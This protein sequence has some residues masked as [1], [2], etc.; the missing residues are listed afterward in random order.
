MILHGNFNFQLL[1]KVINGYNIRLPNTTSYPIFSSSRDFCLHLW[2]NLFFRCLLF[3]QDTLALFPAWCK[4]RSPCTTNRTASCNPLDQSLRRFWVVDQW[5]GSSRFSANETVGLY[6]SANTTLLFGA[7]K[8][9]W[10]VGAVSCALYTLLPNHRQ[11]WMP[12]E[13]FN[14][15]PLRNVVAGGGWIVVLMG[16]GWVKL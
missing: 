14:S 4:I 9:S 8:G 1:K 10:E 11:S 3:C 16:G 15:W 2:N 7:L 12:Q 13:I 6:K 5:R